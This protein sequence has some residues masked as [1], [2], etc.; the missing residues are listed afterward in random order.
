MKNGILLAVCAL[1]T[2]CNTTLYNEGKFA[3]DATPQTYEYTNAIDS[4]IRTIA[5]YPR[6]DD[7]CQT[8]D[9]TS[10]PKELV[11]QGKVLIACPKHEM[12]ALSDRIRQGASVVAHAK[13]WT[14]LHAS[15]VIW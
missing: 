9:E 6:H 10:V 3:Y 8:V 1:I 13:H 14:L 15:K 5:P 4:G 2:A 11:K 12:G 7:V